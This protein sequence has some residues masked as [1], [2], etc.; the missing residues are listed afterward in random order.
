MDAPHLL[1]KLAMWQERARKTEECIAA[2]REGLKFCLE[3]QARIIAELALQDVYVLP[4]RE[5]SHIQATEPEGPGD[6][7]A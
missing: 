5:E 6:T 3:Q 4:S 1:E 7:G 2:E